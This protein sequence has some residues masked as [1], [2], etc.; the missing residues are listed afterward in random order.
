MRFPHKTKLS[1]IAVCIGIAGLGA[2]AYAIYA[3]SG[4]SSDIY[5]VKNISSRA[6]AADI[7]ISMCGP[8][9]VKVTSETGGNKIYTLP[10][11]NSREERERIGKM[12]Q[13]LSASKEQNTKVKIT[14]EGDTIIAVTSIK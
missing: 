6:C 5:I 2:L 3:K 4:V 1:I 8:S 7:P 11:F 14:V 13:Q 10:G 9:Q 12:S